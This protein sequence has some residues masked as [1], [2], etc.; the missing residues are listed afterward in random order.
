[1]SNTTFKNGFERPGALTLGRHEAART[2]VLLRFSGATVWL[3]V[4]KV[5]G[6]GF[7]TEPLG[8]K[9]LEPFFAKRAPANILVPRG[10]EPDKGGSGIG[11]C[12][13]LSVYKVYV[14]RRF[15][16]QR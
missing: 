16:L 11:F 2:L 10:A 6:F 3:G 5:Q 4:E 9:Q 7:C 1:M 15:V 14:N 12:T 13:T 8:C